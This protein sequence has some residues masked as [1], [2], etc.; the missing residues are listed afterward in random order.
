MSAGRSSNYAH[1]GR[2]TLTPGQPGQERR[3]AD[4][5]CT[6]LPSKLTSSH[7]GVH[8]ERNSSDSPDAFF[9]TPMSRRHRKQPGVL[10]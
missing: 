1:L 4:Q 10:A 7:G 2:F 3:G 8:N 6:P 9:G 5:H